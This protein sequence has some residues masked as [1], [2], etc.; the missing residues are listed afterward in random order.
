VMPAGRVMTD[1]R[2]SE[3]DSPWFQIYATSKK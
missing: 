3:V 2:V 1:D